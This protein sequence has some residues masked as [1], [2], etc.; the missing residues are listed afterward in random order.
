MIPSVTD[1]NTANTYCFCPGVLIR[2]LTIKT[3]DW[4]SETW[5][6]IPAA[7]LYRHFRATLCFQHILLPT[8]LSQT[9]PTSRNPS[10]QPLF[11]FHT[12]FLILVLYNLLAF[13]PS[14]I[15]NKLH[16]ASLGK[17]FEFQVFKFLLESLSFQHDTW[18]KCYREN[19]KKY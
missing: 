14:T 11:L 8:I 9:S 3:L 2:I 4:G 1:R 6:Q 10:P 16:S 19:T 12:H 5:R 7:G 17:L 18:D 15:L 13:A